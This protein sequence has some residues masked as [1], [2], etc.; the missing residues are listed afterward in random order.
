MIED[1]EMERLP[2]LGQY[3]CVQWAWQSL[4]VKSLYSGVRP[5]GHPSPLFTN[6][7]EKTNISPPQSQFLHL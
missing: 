1:K 4:V 6:M 5:D 2:L 7:S 3:G